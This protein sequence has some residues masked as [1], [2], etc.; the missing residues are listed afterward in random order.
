MVDL[1]EQLLAVN[2]RIMSGLAVSEDEWIAV[3]ELTSKLGATF[4]DDVDFAWENN[5]KDGPFLIPNTDLGSKELNEHVIVEETEEDSEH[6]AMAAEDIGNEAARMEE[7]SPDAAD[8][9]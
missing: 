9:A 4:K 1:Q 7:S 6:Q 5:R 3:R 2:G 8:A